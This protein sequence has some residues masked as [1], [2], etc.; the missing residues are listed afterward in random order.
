MTATLSHASSVPTALAVSALPIAPAEGRDFEQYGTALSIAAGSTESTGTVEISAVDNDVDAPDRIVS[1]GGHAEN[2]LGVSGPVAVLLTIADDDIAGI[3]AS[4]DALEVAEG[5]ESGA[6]Y[7]LALNSRPTGAVT[8]IVSGMAGTDVSARP[9]SL[10]FTAQTWQRAQEVRVTAGAD[11]DSV[12][13]AVILEHRASGGGYGSTAV[14]T[15]S[16]TVLD[17]D[18][19]IV[20]SAT[21]PDIDEGA[22]P[23]S[24]E[25]RA[26]YDGELADT[27]VTVRVVVGGETAPGQA[28]AGTDYQPV[29]ILEIVIPAGEAGGT[30]TFTFTPIEDN[31]VEPDEAVSIAGT[32][33]DSGIPISG[34]EV[35]IADND[36]EPLP[37][38]SILDL[39][40]NE[41]DRLISFEVRLGAASDVPVRVRYATAEDT[42][43]AR[44]DYEPRSGIM[45]FEPG[46]TRAELN[47]NLFADSVD[48]GKERF[49]V[50]LS[51][52][53]N[54][55]LADS[56][57][58]G[59]I[60]NTDALPRAWLLMFGRAVAEDVAESVANRGNSAREAGVEVNIANQSAAGT[61]GR[62]LSGE[63]GFR[64][65]GSTAG[66]GESGFG[67]S[68]THGWSRERLRSWAVSE[69]ELLEGT[70]YSATGVDPDGNSLSIWGSG[71]VS[72]F[73]G[74]DREV[75][76]EGDAATGLIGADYTSGSTTIG[77]LF[78]RSTGD[79][80]YGSEASSGEVSASLTGVYPYFHADAADRMS[81]WG[82]A[83]YGRGSIRLEPKEGPGSEAGSSMAMAAFGARGIVGKAVAADLAIETDVMFVRT[84]S[85]RAPG[86]NA[87]NSKAHRVR[88]ALDGSYPVEVE[89][90]GLLVPSLGVGVQHDGGDA[91]SGYG[92]DMGVG[93]AARDPSAGISAEIRGRTLLVHEADGLREW[94][95]S[96]SIRYD[97]A[98]STDLGL[99][100]SLTSSRGASARRTGDALGKA[101]VAGGPVAAT[102][103]GAAPSVEA[104]IGYGL[105]LA[106]CMLTGRP[107][108]GFGRSGS[109][110]TYRTGFAI[111]LER[112]DRVDMEIGMEAYRRIRQRFGEFGAG[113][114]FGLRW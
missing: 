81:L 84:W 50:R 18:R 38:I 64:W 53:E 11:A 49:L 58:V 114:T 86:L 80:T 47:V 10:V 107:S 98:P 103:R 111:G 94:G 75:S 95:L 106:D 42:A 37:T 91:E 54:A 56:E 43:L 7:A 59:T 77:L 46:E 85:K 93:I 57:A 34:T 2:I 45:V 87:T 28:I 8:V 12:N 4:P 74:S 60:T 16:V 78:S 101:G 63:D 99:E 33:D 15:V 100:L 30:G 113:I 23:G 55:E 44:I 76:L 25:V 73:Q 68:A 108:F 65:R 89:E 3:S 6:S 22:G 48:E 62:M 1:V 39:T 17:D 36:E 41:K 13:D 79:G 72:R 9:A 51:D 19:R 24:V 90:V 97:S 5:D 20:L 83:G 70:S 105:P 52:P 102:A 71:S 88:I 21:P 14:A 66:R 35:V 69:E 96:G 110:R 92:V 109:A 27:V 32:A 40:G 26:S 31:F 61:A 29:D 112:S 104:E 67:L 82:V